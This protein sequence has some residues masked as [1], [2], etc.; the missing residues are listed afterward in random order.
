[1]SKQEYK[2]VTIKK[3]KQYLSWNIIE[4][5]FWQRGDS[6]QRRRYQ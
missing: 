4:K 1:M 6:N 2:D 3:M 5:T